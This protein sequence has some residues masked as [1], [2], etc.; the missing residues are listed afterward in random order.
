M[1]KP[2]S[3]LALHR[4]SLRALDLQTRTLGGA[5]L[6]PITQARTCGPYC[7]TAFCTTTGEVCH[8]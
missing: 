6:P 7:D 4:E 8:P 5:T 3:K 2:T 1:K